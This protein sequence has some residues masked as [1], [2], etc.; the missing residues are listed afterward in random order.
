MTETRSDLILNALP[1][2]IQEPIRSLEYHLRTQL[3]DNRSS[4]SVV[5]SA[6]TGDYRPG[7][8]D[9]NTVLVLQK[10]ETAALNVIAALAKPMRK[11]H[12]SPPLLMT[13]FYIKRSADVFGIEFLDFQLT[14]QTVLG[15]DPFESL[16][17]A[18]ADVRLQCERELKATL[19]RLRQGYI[20]AA[21][22]KRLVRDL[23][24]AAAKGLA[25]VLR[26]ILWLKNVERPRTMPGTWHTAAREFAVNLNAVVAAEQWRY[27]KAKPSEGDLEDAFESVYAAVDRL[28]ATVDALEVD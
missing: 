15:N 27:E 24:I 8:S 21:T 13:T 16:T 4:I 14:H 1:Q 28:A 2:A 7:V 26:A 25:P 10:V 9:I 3:A 23:L 19:I 6:L 12:L 5:G 22:H 17:F 18:K 11:Q 20:A